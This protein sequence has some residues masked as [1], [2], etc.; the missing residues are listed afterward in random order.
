MNKIDFSD[1]EVFARLEDEAIDGTLDYDSFPP[2]EYKYF[3]QLAKL[4]YKNR[5]C[6]WSAE[7]CEDKQQ[8]LR[9]AY[10]DEKSRFERFYNMSCVIQANIFAAEEKIIELRKTEGIYPKLIKACEVIGLMTGDETLVGHIKKQ[11]EGVKK[12]DNITA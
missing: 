2:C 10:T 4:G 3:S 12:H 6:G 1:K 5:H 9:R 8:T 7:I 11:V